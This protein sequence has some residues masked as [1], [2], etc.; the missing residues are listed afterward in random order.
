MAGAPKLTVANMP[1]FSTPP[2]LA[3]TIRART[4]RVCAFTSGSSA[5]T[6]SLQHAI[7]IGGGTRLDRR[8]DAHE[9]G[10]RFRHVGGHPDG[11]D[12]GELEQRHAGHHRHAV[13][14]ADFPDDAGL[15]RGHGHARRRLAFALDARDLGVG[16]AEQAQALPRGVGKLRGAGLRARLQRQPFLLRREPLGNVEIGE[17]LPRRDAVV[18]RAHVQLLDVALAARLHGDE[19]A[20]VDADRRPRR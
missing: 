9:P 3:S 2:G 6:R 12:A 14:R 19:R 15:R 7:R 4:V 16:H 5:L 10:L 8:A 1:G 17:R 20:L 13:A 11:A 18:L